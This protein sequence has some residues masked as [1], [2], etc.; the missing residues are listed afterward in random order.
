MKLS[1]IDE[2]PPGRLPIAT[3]VIL[4][5]ERG[6]E[7]VRPPPRPHLPAMPARRKQST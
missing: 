2:M 1:V 6:R 7:Q 5:N 3:T 4:D